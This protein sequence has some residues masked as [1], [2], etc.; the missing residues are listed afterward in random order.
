MRIKGHGDVG[1]SILLVW[2]WILIAGWSQSLVWYCTVRSRDGW[3][4]RYR[5]ISGY[6]VLP[7]PF[8]L[9]PAPPQGTTSPCTA[10][11]DPALFFFIQLYQHYHQD[12]D[13]PRPQPTDL[14]DS[15]VVRSGWNNYNTVY[16]AV[17]SGTST[18]E[19]SCI[20]NLYHHI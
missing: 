16:P 4:R 3:Y 8:S 5:Q 11:Q 12:Q 17:V 20:L 6:L 10:I 2:N 1:I 19:Y 18:I 15:G 14:V 7:L 13:Q 9:H